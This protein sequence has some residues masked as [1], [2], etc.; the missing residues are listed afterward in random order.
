MKTQYKVLSLFCLC[1]GIS[2]T[3]CSSD[4]DDKTVDT[5]GTIKLETNEVRI[6]L[7]KEVEEPVEG[8]ETPI[9]ENLNTAYVKVLSGN[10]DYSAFSLNERIVTAEYNIE[11]SAIKINATAVGK[12]KI[13]VLDKSIES[14]TIN[15]IVYENDYIALK[16]NEGDLD[17]TLKVGEK[18][19]ET[20]TIEGGNNGFKASSSDEEIVTATI[21]YGSNLKLTTPNGAK[22]GEAI[23]TI[24]DQCDVKLE[25]KIIITTTTIPYTDAELENLRMIDSKT[26]RFNNSTASYG[27]TYENIIDEDGLNTVGVS[28]SNYWGGT[29]KALI[30]FPGAREVRMIEDAEIECENFAG[31]TTEGKIKL[32]YMNIFHTTD[33]HFYAAFSYLD[34]DNVLR[35]GYSVAEIKPA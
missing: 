26:L 31:I 32:T 24:T 8:E 19:N 11:S 33:T 20:F 12:A 23:V 10:G 29:E 25:V 34:K 14:S 28:K 3:S 21:T 22:D 18:L 13:M 30:T 6:K 4:N 5:T 16:D 17:F 9:D 7:Q 35:F 1:F 2:M 27:Y 15:A